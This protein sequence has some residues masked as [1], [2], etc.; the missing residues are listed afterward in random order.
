MKAT[1]ILT[2]ILI[3]NAAT[4]A[5]KNVMGEAETAGLG[6]S[7]TQPAFAA[8]MAKVPNATAAPAG[9]AKPTPALAKTLPAPAV[10][11]GTHTP[12]LK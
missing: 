7:P 2:A 8:A 1:K 4:T 5:Q 6:Q 11:V 12:N 9:P 10:P 3:K